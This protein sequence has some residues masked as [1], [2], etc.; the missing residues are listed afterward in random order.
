MDPTFFT[1]F[2]LL[3]ASTLMTMFEQ[4]VFISHASGDKAEYVEPLAAALA[5]HGVSYWLDSRE[6]AWGDNIARRINEGLRESRFGLLCLSERYLD[7]KWTEQ[8]LSALFAIENS[9][10][11]RRVLPLILNSRD[12]VLERYPLIAG[13]A[14]RE[15]AAGPDAIASDIA[16]L[17][18]T[19][20]VPD[21]HVTVSIESV[22]TGHI[23]RLVVPTRASVDFL[24]QK[25]TAGAGLKNRLETG[26]FQSFPI[27]W[28][29][30]DA[31]VE[32]HVESLAS[33]LLKARQSH[34]IVAVVWN[35]KRPVYVRDPR[36]RLSDLKGL[37]D[38]LVFHL[39]ALPDVGAIERDDGVAY[40]DV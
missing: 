8:E 24:R 3:S 11:E 40:C 29:L 22:H 16:A 1:L 34:E 6:I 4:D 20:T 38:N 5:R 28:V 17:A 31:A 30:V 33:R 19:R 37:G 27:R 12:A 2:F 18:G 35:G 32:Q 23:S 21:D 13:M 14:Y 15:F 25:A 26:G 10:G 36:T 39:Q 7:R 9:D